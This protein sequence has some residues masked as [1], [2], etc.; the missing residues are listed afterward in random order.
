M[1]IQSQGLGAG[2][3]GVVVGGDTRR[4][5]GQG[6][7]PIPTKLP[8]WMYLTLNAEQKGWNPGMHAMM[9][10]GKLLYTT[11]KDPCQ[12]TKPN[13]GGNPINTG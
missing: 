5:G 3:R 7:E 2:E 9:Q 6:E 13:G 10:C 1:D 12:E 11:P 4:K 8:F